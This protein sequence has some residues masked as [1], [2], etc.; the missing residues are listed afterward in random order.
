[1]KI[2][3]D[4][5][6]NYLKNI[7]KKD[8]NSDENIE[9]I[10]KLSIIIP[11]YNNGNYLKERAIKS[12]E[13]SSIFKEIE[14]IIV[15]DGSDDIETINIIKNVKSKHSNVKT[16]FFTK[17]PSKSASR[18]RNK[19][20][21]L[22]TTNYISYLDPDDECVNDGYK[23]LYDEISNKDIDLVIGNDVV[24]Y[25]KNFRV[26]NYYKKFLEINKKEQINNGRKILLDMNFVVSSIQTIIVRKNII[27]ENKL[28]MVE[29]AIGQ[30]TVFFYELMINSNNVKVIDE[31]VNKH[32]MYVKGS[33]TNEININYFKGHL[34]K[35][36]S[37]RKKLEEYNILEDY[38]KMV[39]DSY[40]K[41][42]ILDKL[43]KVSENELNEAENI[44]DKIYKVYEDVWK[45][46]NK[47]IKIYLKSRGVYKDMNFKLSVIVAIYNNGDYLLNRAFKSLQESS[48][49][50]ELEIILVDD[51]STD[52]TTV[53]II[54]DI[55]SKYRNVKSYFFE[56]G[57]SKSA[58]RP[59][60]KGLELSTTDYISYLDPDDAS[61]NDCHKKLYDEIQKSKADAVIGNIVYNN[62]NNLRVRD[63][64]RKFVNVNDCLEECTNCRKIL[65]DTKFMSGGIFPFLVKKDILTKN[66]LCM[67]E[68]GL[69][70]D[71]LFFYE[72]MLCLKKVKVINEGLYMYYRNVENSVTTKI[73][74]SY[75]SGQLKKEKV[76]RVKLEQYNVLY[77]YLN[78][79]FDSYFNEYILIKLKQVN[80]E[81]L[82]EAKSI[83]DEIYKIYDDVWNVKYNSIKKYLKDRGIYKNLNMKLSVIVPMYNNGDYLINRSFKSLKESSIFNEIEII[84][85]DDGS[86]DE[87]TVNI[88]KDL[89]SKY[90]NVKSYFFETGGSGSASRPRNKGI[91]LATTNYISYLDPDDEC[92]NDSYKILY[93][94]LIKSNV[95][96]VVGN[97]IYKDEKSS[98]VRDYY[99]YFMNVNNNLDISYDCKKILLD[100]DFM[101][102]G[103]LSIIV[104]KN[105]IIENNLKM[106]EGGIGQDTLFSYELMLNCRS[107]KVINKELYLYYM[108]VEN[109][110]TNSI[111]TSY[112]KKHLKTEIEK[113]KK[114]E[115]YGVLKE[116]VDSKYD[117]FFQA[118]IFEKLK[119]VK[120]EEKEEAQSIVDEIYKIYEDVWKIRY[121]SLTNY[122]ESRKN[123]Y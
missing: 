66:N 11:V 85:V 88:I 18:A 123:R 20:L 39:M 83:V 61:I 10:F 47:D 80:E 87:N 122:F 116:Y 31:V 49:F 62:D 45:V 90:S 72:I 64:Y 63:Y 86:T 32:Y 98:K 96:I 97:V 117:A 9:S 56:K 38:L 40:F 4:K 101:S 13:E 48:I 100:T 54:K 12:L 30:D 93:D 6:K 91:E 19:G 69:G 27:V 106:V 1:M 41:K 118:W 33:V 104:K 102:T 22:S 73:G 37:K 25:N 34:I 75:F 16:Y 52:K 57:G 89:E 59:R 5:I 55:Q 58:S 23:K 43:N 71:T 2:K 114:L 51:G 15:D 7:N 67:V 65:L 76:K 82:E 44:V 24:E 110:I 78:I 70:E 8:K 21:E 109:S 94:T 95:D 79:M 14:I 42:Y 28:S 112:F 74:L 36:I 105:I 113:R 92:I 121:K 103:I 29:G 120:V 108:N 50:N 119:K 60:N 46:K 84:L 17:G 81:E 99:K 53:N 111:G 26:R 68:G 3:I 107:I 77:D 35:E 115:N